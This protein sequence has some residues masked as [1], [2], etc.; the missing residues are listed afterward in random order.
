M[1]Q[2]LHPFLTTEHDN[3]KVIILLLCFISRLT[4]PV[5]PK[6]HY[7]YPPPTIGVLTNIINALASSPRFYTQVLHLMN[8]LNLPAPFG[9][10]TPAPPLVSTWCP[11][12]P[13]T[14]LFKPKFGLD[15][16]CTYI[17]YRTWV[18]CKAR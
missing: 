2:L 18:A 3:Y 13:L 16:N 7:R 5:N 8:K 17:G 1:S 10:V 15:T 14:T 12:N 4:Y 6:L 11:K 9:H